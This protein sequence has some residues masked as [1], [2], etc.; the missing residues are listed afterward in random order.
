MRLL[1]R[2]LLLIIL[3]IYNISYAQDQKV[4]IFNEEIKSNK[5][6]NFQKIKS[7]V[8][9]KNAYDFMALGYFINANNN[10][11]VKT[12]DKTYLENNL[13]IIKPILIE[14]TE[15][16]YFNNNWKMNAPINNQNSVVNGKEHQISEGYFFRYVGE[17]LDII[18][19]NNLYGNYQNSILNGLKYSFNKWKDKSFSKYNDYSLLFHQYL[20]TGANWAIVAL[21]LNKYDF[22]NSQTYLTFTNQFDQQ[23]RT[24]LQLKDEKGVKYYVWNSNYPERFCALLK[25]IKNY[26]PIIQDVSHGNH[27][28]LYLL[29]AKEL[30]NKNWEN[31]NFIYLAN[32]LKIKILKNNSIS[33]N[34]DGSSS[35]AVKNTG[36]KISDGWMKL[37]YYDKSLYPLFEKSLTNYQ[38]KINNS[39]LESQFNSIYP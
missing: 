33:D 9:N 18:S 26:D 5:K 31:F 16:S 3:S 13:T 37:I 39:V 38:N 29:K 24:A 10:M 32:T 30:K 23:L 22:K 20:H 28:V 14:N 12:G 11:Y 36:W 34:V 2:V 17:F 15:T 1:H 4:K 27:V 21:Y 7:F 25:S 8:Q 6:Y 19:K 35:N